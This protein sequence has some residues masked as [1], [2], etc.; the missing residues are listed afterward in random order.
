MNSTIFGGIFPA[1]GGAKFGFW[2]DSF[3]MWGIILPLGYLSAFVWH[4]HPIV[5]YAVISSDEIIK[6]LFAAIRYRQY[7]WLNNITR[8]F[9][10][11]R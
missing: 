3:V 1:G 6:L 8:D 5:L 9:T 10:R 2:C 7:R 4:V 11:V